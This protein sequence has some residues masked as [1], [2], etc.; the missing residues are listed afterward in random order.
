MSTILN[1]FRNVLK[2]GYGGVMA[3]KALLRWRERDAQRTRKEV[4]QW[5]RAQARPI[6]AWARRID[7][8]MWEE[9][10]QFAKDQHAMARPRLE[11][12]GI[13]LGGGGAYDL[14]Y[15]LTRKLRPQTVVE[16][17]VAAGYSSR[18]FLTALSKNGSGSLYSSDFPYFRLANPERYVGYIVEPELREGWTLLMAGDQANIPQIA[19]KIEKI[20]LFHYDSDKSYEGR[21]FAYETLESAFH[22]GT[23]VMYDDIQDNAHFRDFVKGQDWPFMV[24]EFEGKWVGMVGGPAEFYTA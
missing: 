12:L 8:L 13:D 10:S 17:G 22:D 19:A 2:P 16:T 20:D 24:F 11:A 7:A 1:L 23:L 15:F 3:H 5:C 9:A 4:E 6:D 18:A 21:R 14:L